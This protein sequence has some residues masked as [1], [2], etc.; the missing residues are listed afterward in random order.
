[1]SNGCIGTW[2]KQTVSHSDL[3]IRGMGQNRRYAYAPNNISSDF[4]VEE[5]TV[6]ESA[7]DSSESKK[8]KMVT[9]TPDNADSV[10]RTSFDL[11]TFTKCLSQDVAL[12][13][14]ER[15]VSKLLDGCVH[16]EIVAFT[17]VAERHLTV[18]GLDFFYELKINDELAKAANDPNSFPNSN[19]NRD[20]LQGVRKH[21]NVSA[22]IDSDENLR[23]EII[24]SYMVTDP[25]V[26]VFTKFQVPHT[27][28]SYNETSHVFH[29]SLDYGVGFIK[30]CDVV[31]LTRGTLYFSVSKISSGIFEVRSLSEMEDAVPQITVQ[32]L[33]ILALSRL[34]SFT[35]ALTNGALW[36]FFTAYA[37]ED[38]IRI[39]ISREFAT[40]S[41]SGLIIELLKDMVAQFLMSEMDI[42]A[43]SMFADFVPCRWVSHDYDGLQQSLPTSNE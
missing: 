41:N 15:A 2:L 36:R 16:E 20:S 10:L 27:R 14:D 24:N 32:V 37:G 33:T 34:K 8:R 18:L 35:C 22:T 9:L 17:S 12:L 26:A 21:F 4:S 43:D 31:S 5:A 3:R 13:E 19:L 29:G 28:V 6:V 1:M 11:K 7:S 39:Y 40:E 23:T 42:A 25:H 30:S 38:Q